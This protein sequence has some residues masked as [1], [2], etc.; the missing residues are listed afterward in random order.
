MKY[1]I[2]IISLIA[3]LSLISV[4]AVYTLANRSLADAQ[5]RADR[6]DAIVRA[7]SKLRI[8][9]L[10]M[11]R[12]EKDFQ[13]RRQTRYADA[14]RQATADALAQVGALAKLDE[15]RALGDSL[16][17]LRSG[18]DAY[19][20]A[21]DRMVAGEVGKGLTSEDGQTGKLR[22]VIHKAEAALVALDDA[23]TMV[24]L[25]S[26]RR[27]EKDFMLRGDVAYLDQA[28]A[29]H[30]SLLAAV[31]RLS[32]SEVR[33]AEVVDEVNAYMA[34]LS[35][36]AAADLA[37]N[38]ARK[39]LSEVFAAMVPTFEKVERYANEEED[40]V[41]HDLDRI[42]SRTTT[43]A[44]AL[45]VGISVLVVLVAVMISRSIV[46]P[47]DAIT[48]IM[49]RLAQGERG[50]AIPFT[51]QK[52]EVG[53]MA[54]A[55][56]VFHQGLV[57]AEQLDAEAKLRQ[58][59]ELERAHRRDELTAAFDRAVGQTL[60]KVAG[61]V[62]GVGD[63]AQSLHVAAEQTASQSATVAA[64]AEESTANVQAV[65]G[66][67]EE[68]EASTQE[69]S[70]RVQETR[71]ISRE[72]VVGI[73][74]AARTVGV[75]SEAAV[76]IGEVVSLINDI[77]ARTNLL[78]L[79]ATIE[80]ARAGEAGKG[81]AVVAGEVK[82]L[83]T[84]TA[85]ATGEI[86]A[87]IASVQDNTR[88]VVATIGQVHGV[89][90]SVDQVVASIA[91][92]VEEQTAATGEIARNVQEAAVGN[93]MVT[94]NISLVSQVALKTGEMANDMRGVARDLDGDA[95]ELRDEVEGFLSRINAL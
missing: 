95:R 1:R 52:D 17:A 16:A 39:A 76:R 70:R 54:R 48:A 49:G 60:R 40:R 26:M 37:V 77:A 38:A 50:M 32:L 89:V 55:V 23:P 56:E 74:D 18:L 86:Q 87:Q 62:R 2:G 24:H 92:A 15:E 75:L 72:A 63:T 84:Q 27:H 88:Q 78:A 36:Y 29:E 35:E 80:A 51:A 30:A 57:R 61:A 8:A 10:E 65:A 59:A 82:S 67:T 9:T 6:F 79:N 5:V 11:R 14:T 12:G 93:A 91:A 71:A 19:G 69:I 22:A 7:S 25:L 42:R 4:V 73:S 94:S 44:A 83:A 21:L 41:M 34:A 28:R 47:I 58:Q 33:R 64:A 20:S 31:K 46:V 3:I 53:T 66:A 13:L 45:A 85:R 43:V 81:F 68:L 90:D